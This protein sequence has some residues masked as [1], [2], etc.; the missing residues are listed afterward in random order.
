MC[1]AGKNLRIKHAMLFEILKGFGVIKYN[2][3]FALLSYAEK[4]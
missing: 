2:V 4:R 3:G 1:D